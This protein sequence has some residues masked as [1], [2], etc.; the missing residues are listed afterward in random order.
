M[1][2]ERQPEAIVLNQWLPPLDGI[3]ALAILMVMLYHYGDTIQPHGISNSVAKWLLDFGWSGV[4]LFFVLSGFLIT[5]I[6]LNSRDA[7]NYF[8]AF[9]VRRILRIVPVYY[10][11]LVIILWA[12][13]ALMHIDVPEKP[14]W[15][16]FY[17]QNWMPWFFHLGR[18]SLGHFW[19]LGVEEQFYLL[20]P[21]VVFR[22][23]SRQSLRIACAGIATC[24]FLRI[25]FLALHVDPGIIF[26]NTFTR[27][28]ALM[29]GAALACLAREEKWANL[30][31]RN[32]WWL[33]LVPLVVLP[34]LHLLSPR[35]SMT[36]VVMQTI[37]YS[38]TALSYSALLAAVVTTGFRSP[39]QIA[40]SN[41]VMRW[42]G[43]MS[44]SAYIWHLF[45]RTAIISCERVAFGV[46][47]PR[48]V[49]I[50]P[51][52]RCNLSS[53]GMQL[54]AYRAVLPFV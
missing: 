40:F 47:F 51:L 45:V 43:K 50:G 7:E 39:L 9:Y 27:M 28:D 16:I 20:W 6:L 46:V 41:P 4:D 13:P 52:H 17:A 31:R 33:A 29:S 42:I 5:G 3:R 12:A 48:P 14:V 10:F 37:G 11:S 26:R 49:N 53:G 54:H 32:S 15:Y 2:D 34:G 23:D 44:Y 18:D 30:L 36:D 19:S 8:S 38:A 22:F 1:A 25:A 21:L 35:F 24:F